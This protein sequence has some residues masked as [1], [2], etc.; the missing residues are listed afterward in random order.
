MAIDGDF[1]EEQQLD[2]EFLRHMPQ[3]GGAFPLQRVDRFVDL[4]RIAAHPAEWLV[5]VGDER[6]GFHAHS[7]TC[8]DE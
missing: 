1:R 4:E 5:H 7:L 6:D 2:G 8:A 3:I